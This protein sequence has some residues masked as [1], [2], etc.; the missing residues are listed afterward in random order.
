VV[1]TTSRSGYEEDMDEACDV[2]RAYRDEEV[3]EAKPPQKP[4]PRWCRNTGPDSAW[5]LSQYLSD[6]LPSAKRWGNSSRLDRDEMLRACRY[7]AA[8][9]DEHG[10][11]P[12][13][14][15]AMVD[16]YVRLVT[17]DKL[18]SPV[19]YFWS[20]RRRLQCEITPVPQSSYSWSG[21]KTAVST[22]R[23]A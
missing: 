9:R 10:L 6:S 12:D 21:S 1:Q 4:L 18:T 14:I 20:M 8:L 23:W 5:G 7:M 11:A 16:A 3:K 19:G 13:Q 15:R 22:P 17:P 2:G